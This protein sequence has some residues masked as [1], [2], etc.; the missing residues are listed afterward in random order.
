M[1]IELSMYSN[2]RNKIQKNA[3]FSFFVAKKQS[4]WFR[5]FGVGEKERAWCVTKKWQ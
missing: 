4:A 1:G 3:A 2:M 5:R